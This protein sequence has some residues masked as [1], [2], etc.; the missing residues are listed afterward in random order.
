MEYIKLNTKLSLFVSFTEVESLYFILNCLCFVW[1]IL[2]NLSLVKSDASLGNLSYKLEQQINLVY[3][4]LG[5]RNY[6]RWDVR[7]CMLLY[8]FSFG[9]NRKYPV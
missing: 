7:L 2:R 3:K 5:I 4:V 9:V 8:K 1:N 6:L